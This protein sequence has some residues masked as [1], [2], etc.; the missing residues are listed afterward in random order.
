MTATLEVDERTE[1]AIRIGA[2]VKAHSA[3]L[4]VVGTIGRNAS[5]E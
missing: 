4:E 1:D 3:D 5:R 2:M